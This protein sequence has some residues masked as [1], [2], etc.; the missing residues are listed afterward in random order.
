MATQEINNTEKFYQTV[1]KGSVSDL[2]ELINR[3]ETEDLVK[4]V[5]SSNSEGETP[6]LIAVKENHHNMV[7]FLVNDLKADILQTGR[8]KWKEIVYEEAL[9]LFVAILSDCT[10]DQDIINFL[11]AKDTSYDTA[12]VLVPIVVPETIPFSQKIDMLDLVGAAYMLHPVPHQPERIWFATRCWSIALRLRDMYFE[13]F[14]DSSFLKPPTSL[15][16]SAQQVFELATEFRTLDELQ[17]VIH[18]REQGVIRF[19]IQALLIIQRITKRLDPDPH[20]FFL[21]CLLKYG[22]EWYQNGNQY[23]SRVDVVNLILELFHSRQWKDVIDSDW[24][25]NFLLSAVVTIMYSLWMEKE[26]PPNTSQLPFDSIMDVI[27]Y[28]TDLVF[29]LQKHPDPLQNRKAKKFVGILSDSIRMFIEN[30]KETSPEFQKWLSGYFKFTNSHPGVYTILHRTC[31]KC[32]PMSTIKIIQLFI[33]GK[34]DPNVK[35]EHGDTPLHCL[36]HRKQFSDVAVAATK[37]LLSVGAHLDQSNKKGV[38]PLDLFKARKTYL[39]KKGLV[40]DPY[41]Q[42]L[43]HTL[44][45][46]SCLCAQ[47]IRQNSIPFEEKYQLPSHLVPFIQSHSAECDFT[48]EFTDSNPVGV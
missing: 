24:Y 26:P 41:I 7:K 6:L 36:A 31:F 47:V 28:V 21:L 35:N 9:P 2:Q 5:N 20:P 18:N 37:L 30:D 1:S 45:P 48:V 38:T 27:N 19:E 42:K 46:L 12:T 3:M 14:S 17:E 8:F 34:V 11:V 22:T 13:A 40:P 32:P 16:A 10:S 4:I 43:T 23:S 25:D 29:H 15:P 44:L 39:D 33:V